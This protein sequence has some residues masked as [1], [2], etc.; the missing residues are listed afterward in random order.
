MLSVDYVNKWLC[1]VVVAPVCVMRR[2]ARCLAFGNKSLP[3]R[4]ASARRAKLTWENRCIS[5]DEP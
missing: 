2:R 3:T 1:S 4:I 5:W